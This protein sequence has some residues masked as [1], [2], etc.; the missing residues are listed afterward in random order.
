MKIIDE[1]CKI[2]INKEIAGG[3]FDMTVSAPFI[4]K[5]AVAGQFVNFYCEGKPLRRPISICETDKK[6][7]T[8]RFVYL[9]KGGGTKYLSEL[10]TNDTAQILGPLGNGFNINNLPENPV[11]VAGGIGSPPMLFL[12]KQ[13]GGD[14]ILGFR[15][16]DNVILINEFEKFANSV[17]YTTDDGNAGQKGFVTALLNER[18]SKKHCGVIMACGPKP[19]LSAVADIAEKNSIPC[20]LSLE[21]HMGCGV[22]ACLVC[23]CKVRNKDNNEEYYAHICKDGPVF[24]AKNIVWEKY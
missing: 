5:N 3:V 22:G 6:N 18:L 23:A 8:A 1:K 16:K 10:K 24:N 2:I 9:V 21:E 11:I 7:E 20:F 12:V 19:M 14:V 13:T 15:S 17:L 4:S